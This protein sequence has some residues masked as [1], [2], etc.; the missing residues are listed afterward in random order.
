M[1]CINPG[2]VIVGPR[3]EGDGASYLADRLNKEFGGDFQFE[4]GVAD[5][6][7]HNK[8]EPSP[9]VLRTLPF[10]GRVPE[11]AE[12]SIAAHIGRFD[13]RSI[14]AATPDYLVRPS[15]QITFDDTVLK[16]ALRDINASPGAP[17]CGSGC[18]I[19]ILDSGIDP[20]LVPNAKLHPNQ[21]DALAPSAGGSTLGDPNGHGSLVARIISAVA[22]G[23]TLLSIK[24]FD[25]VGTISSVVAALYVAQAAGPCDVLNLSFSVSCT[26]VPC[27]V[28][29]TPT[30][31]ATNVSQLGYFFKTFF[32]NATD[33]ILVAAGG[34]N[35]QQLALPANFDRVLAVGSFDYGS[36]TPISTY[37]RVPFDRFVLAPGGQNNPGQAY[38]QRLGFVKP[39]YLYGTSFAAAFV[40]G[41]AAKTI[42]SFKNPKCGT[43]RRGRPAATYGTGM[44]ASVLG[45]INNNA[46]KTWPGFN[47]NHHGLG[48]IRF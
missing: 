39:E 31:A 28:C 46:D 43:P 11:G 35:V 6:L 18:N 17:L 19:G 8:L 38:A 23:A 29:Q 15:A 25:N 21:Y 37:Q 20:L 45:E 9:K 27:T 32:Q 14:G 2:R 36:Q 7:R 13:P 3:E 44:L 24:T 33:A 30:P 26:P 40:S 12:E 22:P 42:C 16:N 47:P 10:V 5:V 1:E 48:A 4:F 41:F 34:N